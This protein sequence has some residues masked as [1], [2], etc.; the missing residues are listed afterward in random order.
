MTPLPPKVKLGPNGQ[1]VRPFVMPGSFWGKLSVWRYIIYRRIVQFT[2]LLLFFGTFHWGWTIFEKPVLS[3]NLSS[4]TLLGIIPMADPFAT[5]QMLLTQHWLHSD[6]LIGASIIL[7]LYTLS[8]R[9]WCSW[10]C[11]VNLITDLAGWL[12][13]RLNIPD[14]F[15]VQRKTRYY[16]LGLTLVLSVITGVAAFEWV[17][18]ISVFH[19]GVIFGIGLGW[20]ALVAIFVFDLLILKHGWCGH[21]C[22]LGAFYAL[23]G[24]AAQLRISFDTPTCTHCC[25][26][27]RVCPEPQVLNFKKAGETGMISSGECTNCARCITVCPEDTLHLSL[28]HKITVKKSNERNLL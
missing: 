25:E 10:V 23:T 20:T 1:P 2:T 6:V 9:A 14:A 18:P 8:G 22:P 5:L 17:S 3:G 13:K 28:R 27:V 24:K 11:P 15:P 7:L 19:R 16:V 21:L 26:C 4:S 12:R